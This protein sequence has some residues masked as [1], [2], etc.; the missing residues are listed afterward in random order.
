MSWPRRPQRPRRA[1]ASSRSPLRKRRLLA[2]RAWLLHRWALLPHGPNWRHHSRPRRAPGTAAWRLEHGGGRIPL[3]W[4]PCLP[5]R[6]SRRLRCW[7]TASRRSARWKTPCSLLRHPLLLLLA[8]AQ[9][10]EMW[11]ILG[12]PLQPLACP[13]PPPPQPPQGSLADRTFP[14]PRIH[15]LARCSSA[16]LWAIPCPPLPTPSLATPSSHTPLRWTSVVQR[17]GPSRR[18]QQYLSLV[19][20]L[21]GDLQPCLLA[22]SLRPLA[23]MLCCDSQLLEGLSQVLLSHHPPLLLPLAIRF[24]AP[25]PRPLSLALRTNGARNDSRGTESLRDRVGEERSSTSS[26]WRTR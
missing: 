11:R 7:L 15:T 14:L 3:G 2:P 23:P 10:L 4:L 8:P 24:L 20:P 17:R 19:T 1:A 5:R 26:S 13:L 12:G 22:V 18:R 21:W 9:F 6:A 25:V 16:R